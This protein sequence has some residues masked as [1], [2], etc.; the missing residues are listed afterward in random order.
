M[1]ARYTTRLRRP[2]CRVGNCPAPRPAP[3]GSPP[4]PSQI[5]NLLSAELPEDASLG[6]HTLLIR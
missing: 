3:Q 5:T 1:P 6:K 4:L 2:V